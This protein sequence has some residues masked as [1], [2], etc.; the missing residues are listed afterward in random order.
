MTK[1]ITHTLEEFPMP[2]TDDIERQVIADAILNPQ[3]VYEIQ[4]LI[5]PDMFANETNRRIWNAI[6]D[7]HSKGEDIDITTI[8]F[9]VDF[10]YFR[11]KI[12]PVQASIVGQM[13]HVIDLKNGAYRRNS[14]I[15]AMKMLGMSSDSNNTPEDMNAPILSLLDDLSTGDVRKTRH[16]SEVVNDL[17]SNI[18]AS[19]TT[20]VHTGI[21]TLDYITYG[22][23]HGSWLTILAA[24]PGVGKSAIAMHMAQAAARKGASVVVFSLEMADTELAQ[25]MLLSTGKVTALQIADKTVDWNKFDDAASD[26]CMGN[27]FINDKDRD[28][29]DIKSTLQAM[30]ARGKCD[31]AIIDYLGLV[32]R[33]DGNRKSRYEIVTE[34]SGDLKQIACELKIPVLALSQLNRSSVSEHREP[35]LYDLRDSGAIEQD[36]DMVLMLDKVDLEQAQPLMDEEYYLNNHYINL[37]VRK[38]RHGIG[39]CK[40]PLHA[41]RTYSNFEVCEDITD[42]NAAP[43]HKQKSGGWMAEREMMEENDGFEAGENDNNVFDDPFSSGFNNEDAP[44]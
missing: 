4:Q 32:K 14:Y 37:Y 31:F 12:I 11:T 8:A 9:T 43:V 26:I 22:G 38:F 23:L 33:R 2:S 6:C 34:N 21:S 35:Q 16:I 20:R 15:T 44:F 17:A 40:I 10:E 30:K 28:I 41:D 42:E 25:R 24:R 29:R 5:S 13:Q 18:E 1:E 3:Q 7:K 27:I 36:A 19:D 39:D